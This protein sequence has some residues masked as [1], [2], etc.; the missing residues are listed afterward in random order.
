MSIF[1]SI[2]AFAVA[3]GV[4]VTVHEYGHYWVARRCGVKV[5]V[6]SIGFGKPLFYWQRGETQWQLA[7]IPLGGF[8]R[9]LDEREGDVAPAE[10]HRAF[11]RKNVW[12][13]MAVVVAGP[14]ANL[15]LAVVIYW[16][17]F[18][19]G[20][21]VL[22]PRIGTVMA[23]SLAAKAGLQSGDMIVRLNGQ[24]QQSWQDVRTNLVDLGSA[25]ASVDVEVE[26]SV[27]GN[28]TH[29]LD[30]SG[31]G[32]E[33]IDGDIAAT[34]GITL[35]KFRPV[36]GEVIP[37]RVAQLA[38]LQAGD[39]LLRVNDVAT[40]DW[41]SFA[42]AIRGRPGMP[43]RIEVLRRGQA[44]AITVTPEA[45]TTNGVSIGVIGVRPAEDREAFQSLVRSVHYG[46]LSALREAISQ[47]WGNATLS[48]KMLGRM[49][50]GQVSVK[51]LSGPVTMASFAGQSAQLGLQAYLVYLCLISV[52]LGVLNL[53]PIPILDGGH[54]LYYLAELLRG[55][56]LSDRV[57]ELGQRV[58]GSLLI[59]L[60]A[61][62][63]YNDFARAM[64]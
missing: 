44:L 54:L 25:R 53:L 41:L 64:S 12:Q 2:A 26:R 31:L 63:L 6:F 24:T 35:A 43:T 11:N 62:A 8:V 55:K 9:M 42:N 29:T 30:L 3:I 13:R 19:S 23:G 46:P 17:V 22:A 4:L 32:N 38:G 51:Q 47:T 21:D 5:L 60:M 16:A 57:I 61:V 1:L 14:L 50:L 59:L 58:G 48:L 10:L 33:Q 45:S 36:L 18:L 39:G 34:I 37:G 28:A 15:L 40:P 20:V 56:P 52:S 49:L 27:G 7:A